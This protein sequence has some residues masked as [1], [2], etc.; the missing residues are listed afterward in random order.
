ML[1]LKLQYFGHL[2]RRADS[3]EKTL[4]LGKIE[5]GR[6]RGQQRMR[7]LDGINDS[8]D[9]SLSKPG[10]WWWTGRPGALQ[11]MGSQRVTDDWATE[12]NW[13]VYRRLYRTNLLYDITWR[14]VMHILGQMLTPDLR[15][16][17]LGEATT[18]GDEWLE[19]ETRGKRQHE[20]AL[21]PTGSQTIPITE[22]LGRCILVG[23]K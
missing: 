2:M 14:D 21:L 4:M 10:S 8:M 11:S 18:F 9:M 15:A 20:L 6:R 7:W 3:F 13:K 23:L 1:K 12:V 22:P 19:H 5:G 17:V 16:R